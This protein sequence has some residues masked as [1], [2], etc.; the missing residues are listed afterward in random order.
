[1]CGYRK[2]FDSAT[3][4]ATVI[5]SIIAIIGICVSY[6]IA[7]KANVI[8]SDSLTYVKNEF[9]IQYT[10]ELRNYIQSWNIYVGSGKKIGREDDIVEI[11]L[12]ICNKSYGLAKDIEVKLVYNDGTSP[13]DKIMTQII[14]VLKGSDV[15]SLL[16]FSPSVLAQAA[17]IY[18]A[19]QKTFKMKI[20][21]SWKDASGKAYSSVEL[22]KLDVTEAYSDYPSRFVFVSQGYYDTISSGNIFKQYSEIKID[23]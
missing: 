20:F 13:D 8:A 10:P 9:A 3:F 19:K 1:M 22:Y 4:K 17:S 15:A 7:A 16:P 21:L 18:G 11:P 2:F 6:Y 12:A 5:S 14:P 23:F